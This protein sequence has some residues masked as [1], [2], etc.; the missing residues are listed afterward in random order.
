VA[1][2]AIQDMVDKLAKHPTKTYGTRPLSDINKLVVHHSAVPPSVGPGRI[3]D[4]HVEK[5][6]WP[7]VGYHFFVGEDGILYQGN[8]L[9]TVSFHAVQ[10]NPTGVGICFLGSFMKKTPPEAQLRAGAHLLAWLMQELDVALDD[11]IGHKEV[12]ATA[13]PGKQWLDGKKWKAQ[14]RQEI[15]KV[16]QEA[17]AGEPGPGP[18]PG[19]KPIY[20]YLLFW[21]HDGDWA[22]Q[23]WIN[24]RNY[25]G[26]FQPSVGFSATDA[27]QAEYV[28]IV[29]GPLGVSQEVEDWLKASGSKV[30]RIAGQDE[31]H[32][33]R[34]LDELVQE[35]RRFQS[36]E[37]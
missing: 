21:A 20:H 27:A 32:T 7:G 33:Q 26:T 18:A 12:L 5:L 19:A 1:K 2:P 28:T 35:G 34:L 25:I 37:E 15:T 8:K 4:Y 22:E 9:Q 6:D 11:V 3:A 31:A 14:L 23:D 17:E 16:Q 13:C 10:A 36:F 30:E 24:A 29:G